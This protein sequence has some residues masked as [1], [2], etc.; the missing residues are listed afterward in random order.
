M[1]PFNPVKNEQERRVSGWVPTAAKYSNARTAIDGGQSPGLGMDPRTKKTRTAPRTIGALGAHLPAHTLRSL[2]RAKIN[3]RVTRARARA[4]SRRT[5][6]K[7]TPASAH[8]PNSKPRRSTT[9]RQAPRAP[10]YDTRRAYGARRQ[11]AGW[12]ARSLDL[13]RVAWVPTQAQRAVEPISVEALPTHCT[14]GYEFTYWLVGVLG[15][16]RGGIRDLWRRD[17]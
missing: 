7:G 12:L 14:A 11:S 5:K 13:W 6:H 4:H 8:A 2:G 9:T 17:G 15:L 1:P 16:R 10:D 3:E